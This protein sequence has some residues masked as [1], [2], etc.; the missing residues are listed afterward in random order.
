MMFYNLNVGDSIWRYSVGTAGI[1]AF[2]LFIAQ[3]I[4]MVES[5]TWLARKEKLERA[6]L[7]MNRIY[8]DQFTAADFADRIPVTNQA[9]KG[10]ANI[11]LIFRG[12]YLPRTILAATVQ[13]AQ[14]IQYFAVG[15][16]LPI[17]SLTL[18]GADF[19][20]ATFGRSSSTCSESSE[21]SCLR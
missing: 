14:S 7:S 4:W 18:F 2:I 17:I 16:Y 10:F 11:A 20:V 6:T 12:T 3:M 21:A 8:G 19:I 9:T 5:P 13:M 1:V 15:W